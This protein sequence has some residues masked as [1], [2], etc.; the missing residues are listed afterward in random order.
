M[1]KTT[2]K[3]TPQSA[4]AVPLMVLGYGKDQKPRGAR[5]QGADANLVARLPSSWTRVYEAK[6]EDL[7]TLAKKLPVGRLYSNGNGFVPNV[8]QNLYSQIIAALALEPQAAVGKDEDLPQ[9]ASGAAEE[10]GRDRAWSSCY[11]ARGA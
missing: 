9:V 10:L 2:A 5:F 8:R 3:A 7:A 1:T 6:T 4:A 11:R